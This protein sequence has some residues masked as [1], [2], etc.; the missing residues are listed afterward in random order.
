MP[1]LRTDHLH[2][3]PAYAEALRESG[4]DNVDA[5]LNRVDGE[6][7]AWSRTTDTLHVPWRGDRPGFYV[8]R[9]LYP[10]WRN[11]LRGALRGTLVGRHRGLAEYA[12]L[13]E[14]RS[15]GICAVRP[16]A[17]GSRRVGGFLEACFLITE[18][19][20]N[21]CNLTTFARNAAQR[22]TRL[23][24]TRRVAMIDALARQLADAHS[25]GFEHG[26]MFWRNILVRFGPTGEPEFLFLDARPRRGR[27]RLA[28][29]I[30]WWMDELA[31]LTASALPF[32]T[33]S[34]R[35]RFLIEYYGARRLPHDVK[36]QIR[37]IDRSAR[38]YLKHE[39][40][41]IRMNDLFDE[42]RRRLAEES[43]APAA[44]PSA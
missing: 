18:E 12:L 39:R 13:N 14:M 30:A 4:I 36:E 9:Y 29:R 40:Q 28:R 3:D 16:V 27:R 37:E 42:W 1:L 38:R 11:R 25:A 21:A 23:T 43:A 33:R 41:R 7:A 31:Q 35:M 34:D 20:P 8:K 10:S 26:Q 44:E 22:M 2:I 5:I 15:L 32:T 6:I 17:Y 24:R 19:A